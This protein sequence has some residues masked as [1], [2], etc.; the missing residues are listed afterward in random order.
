MLTFQVSGTKN[1]DTPTL[2]SARLPCSCPMYRQNVNEMIEQCEYKSERNFEEHQIIMK[3]DNANNEEDDP[4]GIL[5]L[6]VA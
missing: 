2:M 6:T 4:Y 1:I 5:L 3:G